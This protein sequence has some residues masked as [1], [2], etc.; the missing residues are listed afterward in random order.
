MT[1]IKQATTSWSTSSALRPHPQAA[2]RLSLAPQRCAA[3]STLGAIPAHPAQPTLTR[4][5][6]KLAVVP[7]E[8]EKDPT[9]KNSGQIQKETAK[10]FEALGKCETNAYNTFSKKKEK[11][12]NQ[13][14][15]K[16]DSD[17][18]K[19]YK[20]WR[21][22]P[23][24]LS[25]EKMEINATAGRAASKGLG[26]SYKDQGAK[27]LIEVVKHNVTLESKIDPVSNGFRDVKTGLYCELHQI[28]RDPNAPEFVLC[29]PGTG[30]G[31]MNSKQWKNNI[32]QAIGTGKVPAAYQQA[33]ALT[34]LIK[35]DLDKTGAKLT[36]AGH[37]MG[38][39]I[40]N[41]AGLKQDVSSVCYN[42]AALG[43]AC[44]RDLGDIPRER[45]E[46]QTHI[47][48]KGDPVCSP[49]VQQ[50]L[51]SFLQ[52]W[53]KE[54]IWVPRNAGTI[55]EIGK[56]HAPEMGIHER[57][58]LTFFDAWYEPQRSAPE[59]KVNLLRMA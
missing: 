32:K 27:K 18:R 59:S 53:H 3:L 33:A 2:T 25:Q 9:S 15:A 31:E 21:D 49:K 41:Y 51:Q 22:S 7:Q 17:N 23:A 44:L 30:S 14:W 55:Y 47:R 46:K 48:G 54:K 58:L 4:A 26:R 13:V 20:A 57:H 38:G 19:A 5:P 10:V 56:N 29:F 37:S 40:A 35:A 8:L 28:S 34:A 45:L 12:E 16:R 6:L 52:I 42:A 50:K 1:G 43:G 39:G 24:D 36:L 11:S